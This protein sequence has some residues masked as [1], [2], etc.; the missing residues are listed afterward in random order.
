VSEAQLK[1]NTPGT[2]SVGG[3]FGANGQLHVKAFGSNSLIAGQQIVGNFDGEHGVVRARI[4]SQLASNTGF[5]LATLGFKRQSFA[6]ANIQNAGEPDFI[7][8]NDQ[9]GVQGLIIDGDSGNATFAGTVTAN[10]TLLTSDENMKKNI[11]I[12]PVK[13]SL[14]KILSI[15]PI[16]FNYNSKLNPGMSDHTFIGVSAQELRGVEPLLVSDRVFNELGD[17]ITPTGK[18][19][20]HL[21][22]QSDGIQ[23]LLINALKEQNEIV[24]DMQS[25]I[26]DLRSE[27]EDLKLLIADNGNDDNGN[28]IENTSG[29]K[30]YPNPTQ[31]FLN[32][33]Y[34]LPKNSST[35][36]IVVTDINGRLIK[37]ESL[38]NLNGLT[39]LSIKNLTSGIY[40]CTL[41]VDDIPLSTEKI[42]KN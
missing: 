21:A 36:K 5:V 39:S 25:N 6:V 20:E 35:A 2:V 34:T 38:N 11:E 3:T 30:V 27:I 29:F 42:I 8:F 17:N 23:Y 9:N 16:K 12:L 22:I 24:L 41:I 10:G 19:I 40:N 14:E 31:D 33:E 15:K 32:F 7:I 26:K 13:G 4:N 28:D 1:V 18:T 37:T